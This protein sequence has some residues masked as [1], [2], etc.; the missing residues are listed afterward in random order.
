MARKG[1]F[2]FIFLKKAIFH[3]VFPLRNSYLN[4]VEL[5][6]SRGCQIGKQK[7]VKT[8]V[9]EEEWEEEEEEWEDWEEEEEEDW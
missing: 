1:S 4:I 9:E 3:S 2:L 6:P 8:M 5:M 7:E